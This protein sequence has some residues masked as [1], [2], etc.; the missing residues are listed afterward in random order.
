MKPHKQ[1]LLSELA[2]GVERL[3]LGL[4]SSKMLSFCHHLKSEYELKGIPDE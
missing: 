2:H 4:G 1:Y 3:D